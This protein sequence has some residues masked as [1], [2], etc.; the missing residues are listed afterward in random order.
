[1]NAMEFEVE[2][3]VRR[4]DDN[5]IVS[6]DEIN[7]EE[8]AK[9]LKFSVLL[10]LANNKPI[11]KKQVEEV[12]HK[13]WK[14]HEPAVF[15]KVERSVLLVKISSK[16]DQEKILE[17]GPWSVEGIAILVQKW[18]PGMTTEDLDNTCINIWVQLYGL[19]FELR[20][21][22][23][24]RFIASNRLNQLFRGCS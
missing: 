14:L 5:M 4:M 19:P 2:E 23:D 12:L 8:S 18:E 6:L 1:M 22:M 10:K 24:A 21:M 11:H 13:V 7:W 3:V 20:N 15:Y 9:D 17:G 16:E